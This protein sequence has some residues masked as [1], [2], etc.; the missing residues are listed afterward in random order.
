[1]K[2]VLIALLFVLAGGIALAHTDPDRCFAEVESRTNPEKIQLKV[3]LGNEHMQQTF[4]SGFLTE[5]AFL[6]LELPFGP[7]GLTED[8]SNRDL[9]KVS[10]TVTVRVGI[11][12]SYAE[13][14]MTVSDVDCDQV[15][16]TVSS[17]K[18]QLLSALK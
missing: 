10:I 15:A 3:H 9:C 1:M 8:F 17:M 18:R 4:Q 11:D 5:Q 2:R 12:S 16:E 6:A 7:G 13:A 14:S